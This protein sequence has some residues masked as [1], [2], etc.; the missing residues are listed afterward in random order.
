MKRVGIIALL[1]E[2]NTFIREPTTLE[3][4][5]QNLLV[6]GDAVL[7]AFRGSRH[8]VSG[9]IDAIEKSS[10]AR[11]LGVFAARAVPY[12]T[13]THDCWE[14]LLARLR[15]AVDRYGPF[16]GLLV[17]P[18]GATVAQGASDAD[19]CWLLLVR[20]MVGVEIPIVGTLDLHANV[21]QDMVDA[22]DAL[23]GYRTNPHLDQY[24]Q[25]LV[26]GQTLLHAVET[27]VRPQQAL[28]PLPLCVNIERQAT[29][30]PH[31]KRLRQLADGLVVENPDLIAV[32]LVYGFPYADVPEMGASVLA[33]SSGDPSLARL[34][35]Q[36]MSRYWWDQ[37]EH[38][39]G[40]LIEVDE[41]I[42]R[43]LAYRGQSPHQPV[44]LLE[45][46][47]NVGGGGPG[48]GTW[49]A[50]AWRSQGEGRLLCVM[51]DPEAVDLAMKTGIGGQ[52]SMV[53]G[54]KL[55]PELHGPPLE[56]RYFVESL[57]DGRFQEQGVTHGGYSRF[58]QGPT[59]VLRG[60][61]NTTIVATTHRMAPL[62]LQQI[63]SQHL[64]PADF[65]A[66][67]IKGVHAPVAA[68]R[69]VC[70]QLIRVN[71]PGV[72]T[73]DLNQLEFQNR[74]RPMFPWE[75]ADPW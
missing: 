12:G 10:I 67:A 13:I 29:E 72:T 40:N 24:Q 62:S 41:A 22:T 69:Q 30:E 21:S 56:D 49:I 47:D 9:F 59:A 33:V 74:R 1:H 8:E 52:R 15:A 34:A 25:G 28:V 70:S 51:A 65:A 57:T 75:S 61:G 54:G 11:P 68:Y 39:V 66:I 32:S 27:G 44:G 31:G 60:Q 6:E 4:F 63:L 16:D 3:H 18:H 20:G 43:A 35:A 42:R 37:R 19:G 14:S 45:M 17:A 64:R 73:A 36:R 55:A 5:Q 7:A 26:A 58:D 48:D 23:F 71:T 46:G 50:H 53:L 38:F 2:S